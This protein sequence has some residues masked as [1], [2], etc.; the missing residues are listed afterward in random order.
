MITHVTQHDFCTALFAM[1]YS[2]QGL[3]DLYDHLDSADIFLFRTEDVFNDWTEYENVN[4]FLN[5]HYDGSL[6]ELT[7]KEKIYHVEH[8]MNY[9]VLKCSEC[10]MVKELY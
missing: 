1:G 2:H 8:N 3:C 6:N 7:D 4:D 5:E 9:E 10:I